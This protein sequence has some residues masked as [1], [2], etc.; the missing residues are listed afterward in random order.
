MGVMVKVKPLFKN[1]AEVVIQLSTLRLYTR[2]YTRTLVHRCMNTTNTSAYKDKRNAHLHAHALIRLDKQID[3]INTQSGAL[4][5]HR[6]VHI[7]SLIQTKH[8][9]ALVYL[10]IH[11]R[12]LIY[13]SVVRCILSSHTLV[14]VSIVCTHVTNYI[15]INT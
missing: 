4:I 14:Q 6:P 11:V 1:G 15:W 10:Y 3:S 7:D 12:S 8:K 9:Y 13:T 2:I 5:C